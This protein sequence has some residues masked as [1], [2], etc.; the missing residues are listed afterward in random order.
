MANPVVQ[1]F[2]KEYPNAEIRF[3]HFSKSEAQN[4]IDT[5]R[6]DCDNPQ[7]QVKEF[8]RV[9]I[10]E[11]ATSLS[12]VTWIN[13]ENR[14]VECVFKK[15]EVIIPPRTLECLMG[16]ADDYYYNTSYYLAYTDCVEQAQNYSNSC[17]SSAIR[18]QVGMPEDYYEAYMTFE[19][20]GDNCKMYQRID[21]VV[22]SV[23]Y[24][25]SFIGKDMSCSVPMTIWIDAPYASSYIGRCEG[26][27]YDAMETL[28]VDSDGGVDYYTKGVVNISS[29]EFEDW[30]LNDTYVHE[31]Y[32]GFAATNSEDYECPYGC[33]NGVCV[34]ENETNQTTANCTD[35]DDGKN[36]YVKGTITTSYDENSDPHIVEGKG[37]V[38]DRCV[39][40]TQL[41]EYYCENGYGKGISITCPCEDGICTGPFCGDAFCNLNENST[42]CPEDCS[43]NVTCTD[44][45]EGLDYSVKGSAS[46]MRRSGVFENNTDKC[47]DNITLLEWYCIDGLLDGFW[48]ECPSGCAGGACT[49]II[50]CTDSDGGKNYYTYGKI[51]YVNNPAGILAEYDVCDGEYLTERICVDATDNSKNFV[52]YKCPNGCEDGVCISIINCTDTDGGKDYYVRGITS[53]IYAHNKGPIVINDYCLCGEDIEPYEC[54]KILEWYC[55]VDGYVNSTESICPYGCQEGVCLNETDL[56]W[57]CTDSDGNLTLEESYYVH[58]H[59]TVKNDHGGLTVLYDICLS[60]DEVNP[61]DLVSEGPYLLEY[62]CEGGISGYNVYECPTGCKSGICIQS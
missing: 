48:Y 53:G 30:C 42:T 39:N 54:K 28:C 5:I 41:D 57:N 32:C 25:A 56:P 3:T 21:N 10:E 34:Q 45:D 38:T 19:I 18:A 12:V 6:E 13:W 62:R 15:G 2:L 33:S 20:Q 31:M 1:D 24:P 26:S 23:M 46:G 9:R 49:S 8:Y 4:I 47:V 37:H 59:T 27:L 52:K 35:T 17:T 7:L 29:I 58:G 61:P 51:E 14:L 55:D 22:G 36:Y 16:S 11:E 50:N 44:S 43:T 60:S 40:D